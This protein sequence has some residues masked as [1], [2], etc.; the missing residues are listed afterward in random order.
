MLEQAGLP[1]DQQEEDATL[2]RHWMLTP[3]GTG[4]TLVHAVEKPLAPAGS[5]SPTRR[6]ST[7]RCTG[8][9][10]SLRPR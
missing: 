10:G 6:C 1:E 4:W 3:L 2:G 8:F 7:P 9:W 5:R